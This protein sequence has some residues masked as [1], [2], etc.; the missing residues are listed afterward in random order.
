M[1]GPT[2]R[3]AVR[4]LLTPKWLP[5][6]G[7]PCVFGHTGASGSLGFADPDHQLAFGYTPNY[8]GELSG[9]GRTTF[10]F[11]ADVEAAYAA[12]GIRPA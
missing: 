2:G 11:T 8:W 6:F 10:R 1:I 12:A 3:D 4:A 7:V 9:R 5:A